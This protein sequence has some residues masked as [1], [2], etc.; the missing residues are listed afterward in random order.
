MPHIIACILCI[1]ALSQAGA[2]KLEVATQMWLA[3]TASA[4]VVGPNP[5]P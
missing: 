3:G 2:N 5:K 4:L 1:H